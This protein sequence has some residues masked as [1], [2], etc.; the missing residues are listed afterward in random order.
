[1]DESVVQNSFTETSCAAA[2]PETLFLSEKLLDLEMLLVLPEGWGRE[3]ENRTG[4]HRNN[5]TFA[6]CI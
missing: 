6:F 3:Q 2:S 4:F 5:L 1:M